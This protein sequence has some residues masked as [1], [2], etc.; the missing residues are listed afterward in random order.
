MPDPGRIICIAG[1]GISG[2]TLALALAKFGARILLIEREPSIQEFGAGLQISPNARRVLSRLG[3]DRA[4]DEVSFRPEG[5][6][7]YTARGE[8]HLITLQL[9][10]IAEHRYGVPY[11]VMHRQDLAEVLHRACKRFANIDFMFGAKGF[12]VTETDKG[13][14][15]AVDEADGHTRNLRAFAFVGADGVNS[16]TRTL[17]LGLP[18]A[19]ATGLIAWRALLPTS[20][21]W[22][23]IVTNRT[24][25]FFGPGW[26]LVAYPLAHR[27][28]VN[29]ALFLK[30]ELK[31]GEDP[32]RNPVISSRNA[33]GARVEALLKLAHNSWGR[34][35][36]NLVSAPTWHKNSIGLIGDA[37]HAM[38]PFQ[39]Q[40][41]AM[42]IE[43][44]AV[45]APLL[46]SEPTADAAFTRYEQ[47][48][49]NR[50]ARVVKI[51]RS[52]GQIYGLGGPLALG[53]DLV[54]RLGGPTGHLKRLDWLYG[55]DAAPETATE[56]A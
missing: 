10:E 36:L 25:L 9:G 18:A 42:G 28:H 8:K 38:L 1:A 50:V 53:R 21:V 33:P 24:S 11:A 44:A 46:M 22:D 26:H 43:D 4:I 55:Y 37:A 29:L 30:D 15:V 40:G 32:P 54:V 17:L 49:R 31:P 5:I 16:R 56:P 2:M 34:W 27:N 39:A 23:L 47:I 7:V 14:S 3:L 35:P 12:A 52:N 6:D 45:L 20:A 19:Q 48:R 51:S 41:A 13:V